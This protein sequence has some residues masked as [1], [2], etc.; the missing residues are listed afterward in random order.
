MTPEDVLAELPGSYF[1]WNIATVKDLY[2]LT[3]RQIYEEYERLLEIGVPGIAMN[4]CARGVPK[5]NIRAFV[6][7]AKSYDE[8]LKGV[9][10]ARPSLALCC[11][12]SVI[13]WVSIAS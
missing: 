6:D 12:N 9:W 8:A 13:I 11:A 2:T 4:L 1:T 10:T 3:P 7:V 5:E